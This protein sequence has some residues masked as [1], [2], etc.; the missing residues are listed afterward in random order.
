MSTSINSTAFTIFLV[1]V[2]LLG[3]PVNANSDGQC[4]RK[5][6]Q[7]YECDSRYDARCGEPFNLTTSSGMM[8]YCDELCVKL[9]HKFN[10]QFYYI[11]SCA[12]Q[13]KRMMIKKTDVCYANRLKDGSNLCFCDQEYCNGAIDSIFNR[14][15]TSFLL[16]FHLLIYFLFFV[17]F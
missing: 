8:I 10:G 1:L 9:K 11:R 12:D 14:E 3:D 4:C 7:C 2:C 16:F 5:R 13:F 6:I 17:D 15:K